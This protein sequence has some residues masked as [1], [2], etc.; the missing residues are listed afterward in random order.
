MDRP[1][2]T[3][4]SQHRKSRV[5]EENIS[6]FERLIAHNRKAKIIWVHLGMDTTGQRTPALTRR[7]PAA[8]PNLFISI[9]GFQMQTKRNQLFSGQGLD[10]QWR[11]VI[12]AFPDRFMIGG[13][14]FFQPDNPW[15]RMPQLLHAAI[16]IVRAA[17][18]PPDVARKVAFEN[19]QRVFGLDLIDLDDVPLPAG[20]D[21]AV[22]GLRGD[23]APQ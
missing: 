11:N 17:F 19:A 4:R 15:R 7:L 13:D 6:A 10:P 8:H 20:T 5:R 12:V 3:P 23:A 1:A 2:G 9:T 21:G 16:R 14:T 22:P 18:L